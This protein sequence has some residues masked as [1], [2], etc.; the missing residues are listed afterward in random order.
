M[1]ENFEVERGQESR[2][3]GQTV[4]NGASKS[5]WVGRE[6]SWWRSSR[7]KRVEVDCGQGLLRQER[8]GEEAVLA[9]PN[10]D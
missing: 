7:G 10:W 8:E 2:G 9:E 3:V 1:T 5:E 4:E 6:N